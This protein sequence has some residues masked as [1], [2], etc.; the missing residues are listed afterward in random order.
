MNLSNSPKSETSP[1]AMTMLDE[2]MDGA[3]SYD[4][5]EH[6]PGLGASVP[7]CLASS[8]DVSRSYMNDFTAPFSTSGLLSD[9]VPSSSNGLLSVPWARPSSYM[10]NFSE[11]IFAP[12]DSFVMPRRFQSPENDGM[13]VSR[14]LI[15]ASG[16]ATRVYT[17]ESGFFAPRMSEAIRP[18]S[19]P[20]SCTDDGRLHEP[21]YADP[22]PSSCMH[23]T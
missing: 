4:S 2:P 22:N 6:T 17:P 18:A 14:R 10:L 16:S 5:R 20:R 13:N 7:P 15:M 11:N 12:D 21:R 1:G 9:A 19:V 8:A 23:S 3:E